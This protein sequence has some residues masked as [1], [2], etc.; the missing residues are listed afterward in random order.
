MYCAFASIFI[1]QA[2][3][4]GLSI[5]QQLALLL[6]LMVTSKGIAGVPRASL[7]VVAAALPY[8]DIPVAGLLVI[9]AVDH[10]L[11]MGRTATNVIGNAIAAA[12]IDKWEGVAATDSTRSQPAHVQTHLQTQ[13]QTGAHP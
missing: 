11:D 9:I 10:F 5:V 13:M 6:L 2:Y 12:A 4:I 7:V 3:G 1:A 8:F